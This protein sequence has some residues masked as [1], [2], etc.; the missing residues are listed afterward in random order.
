MLNEGRLVSSAAPAGSISG[1][2]SGAVLVIAVFSD[3]NGAMVHHGSPSAAA[4][5]RT[6]VIGWNTAAPRS[7]GTS[8][9]TAA[10]THEA[11]RNSWLVRTRSDARARIRSGSQ[12][13]TQ[14]PDGT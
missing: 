3:W 6:R 1:S 4:A 9:P 13:S 12:A 7:I 2:E 5:A 10:F 11:S 8:P 14:P